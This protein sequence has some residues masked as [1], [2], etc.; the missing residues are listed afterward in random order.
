MKICK[1]KNQNECYLNKNEA[2]RV[3]AVLL[4]R[5]NLETLW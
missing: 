4:P 3:F 5:E 2:I 1:G